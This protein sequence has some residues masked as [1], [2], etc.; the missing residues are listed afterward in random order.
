MGFTENDRHVL[1]RAGWPRGGVEHSRRKKEEKATKQ[2]KEELEA[3]RSGEGVVPC[4]SGKKRIRNLGLA[5]VMGDA[6]S[7]KKM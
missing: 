5:N 2:R 7:R 3:S 1:A 6:S 4:G